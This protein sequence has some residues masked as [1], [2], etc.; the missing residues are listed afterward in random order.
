MPDRIVSIFDQGA[1][2]IKRGKS[3]AEVEFGR[4]VALAESEEGLIIS[5]QVE[6]GNTCDKTLAVPMVKKS[7]EVLNKAPEEVA[8]DRG[9]YSSENER[10]IQGL[11]VEHVAIPKPGKKSEKRLKHERE[12]WFERLIR[13]RAGGEAT[14]GLLKR[15]Y[16]FDVCLFHGEN[17]GI[18]VNLSIFSYN[19]T[20]LAKLMV[21]AC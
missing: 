11:N 13:W 16:G 20:E 6:E 21:Q 2:P 17:T 15:K 12:H 19:V 8:A 1:R 3:K 18:W 7:I 10:E 5:S 14:I 4:K 9:F